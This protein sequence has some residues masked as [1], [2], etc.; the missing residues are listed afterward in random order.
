MN[1]LICLV[2]KMISTSISLNVLSPDAEKGPT[3]LQHLSVQQSL[4]TS[5]CGGSV[6]YRGADPE[7]A[8]P[9]DVRETA[10]AGKP[11]HILAQCKALLS[12]YTDT[13][14][15]TP[16]PLFILIPHSTRTPLL[17]TPF[18]DTS[19]YQ[20]PTTSYIKNAPPYHTST[21]HFK[22]PLILITHRPLLLL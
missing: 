4:I 12:C 3:H 8:S 20:N 11:L 15:T 6:P 10:G 22:N 9:S 2:H 5:Q 7:R 13:P 16:L 18:T 19:Q 17:H 21:S 14:S 1:S